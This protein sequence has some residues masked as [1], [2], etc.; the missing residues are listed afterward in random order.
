MTTIEVKELLERGNKLIEK[1]SELKKH[2]WDIVN[3]AYD[4]K[5]SEEKDFEGYDPYL[6]GMIIVTE[7][8]HYGRETMRPEF[9]P[10]R[11]HLVGAYLLS[12]DEKIKELETE[13]ESLIPTFSPD[14][15][16]PVRRKRVPR[17]K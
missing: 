2:R 4:K 6:N 9:L 16:V 1:I 13:L 12:V 10:S 5:G 11:K 14:M 3:I 7:R 17:R 15:L 8:H